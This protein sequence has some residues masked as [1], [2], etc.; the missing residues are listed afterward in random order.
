[1]PTF[2]Q[3]LADAVRRLS[4]K[5]AVNNAAHEV[6]LTMRSAGELDHQ[7]ARLGTR[8]PRAA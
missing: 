8:P 1:M 6:L 4:G 3:I 7:L 2:L 5:G